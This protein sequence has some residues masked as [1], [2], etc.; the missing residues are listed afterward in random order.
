MNYV[1][2]F[3]NNIFKDIF[4]ANIIMKLILLRFNDGSLL[5]L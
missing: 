3:T 1:T 4:F 5:Q 2:A